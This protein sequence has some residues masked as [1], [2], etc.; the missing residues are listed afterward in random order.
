MTITE[1]KPIQVS[2][3]VRNV[4]GSVLVT[5][6]KPSGDISWGHLNTELAFE[7]WSLSQSLGFLLVEGKHGKV[8]WYSSTQG[9]GT[10]PVTP[11]SP[12]GL[13]STRFLAV[14]LDIPTQWARVCVL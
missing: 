14:L 1:S 9:S 11:E 8:T 12:E 7:H 6:L 5:W 2:L 10:E 13:D 3:H 4:L